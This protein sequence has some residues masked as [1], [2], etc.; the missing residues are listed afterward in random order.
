MGA[1]KTR[2]EKEHEFAGSTQTPGFRPGRV[3]RVCGG[4]PSAGGHAAAAA[5]LPAPW[6]PGELGPGTSGA[7][8]G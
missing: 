6:A 5:Q 7:A 4:H 3:G 1:N 2:H 8:A